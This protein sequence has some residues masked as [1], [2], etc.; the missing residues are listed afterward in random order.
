MAC[1]VDCQ[2]FMSF[3]LLAASLMELVKSFREM[4]QIWMKYGDDL[5]DTDRNSLH[6]FFG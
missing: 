5:M 6:V 2:I 1:L 3:V 4:G